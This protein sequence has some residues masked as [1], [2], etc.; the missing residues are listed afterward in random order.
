MYGGDLGRGT[1]TITKGQK[2][3]MIVDFGTDTM[4]DNNIQT[5]NKLVKFDASAFELIE[6]DNGEKFYI[7]NKGF[8]FKM[9]Y[10]TKQD[11]T[12]WKSQEEMNKTQIE[13]LKVYKTLEEIPNNELCVGVFLNHKICYLKMVGLAG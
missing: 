1:G 5:I 6:F 8:K 10:V 11:G 2:F 12:N 3:R 4:P 13:D 7:N 9:Y